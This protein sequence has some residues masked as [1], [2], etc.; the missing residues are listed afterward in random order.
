MAKEKYRWSFFRAG[1]VDQVLL[2]NGQDLHH[3]GELDRKLWLALSCPTRG[4]EFDYR[5]LDLVDTDRDGHIRPA[6][7]LAAV[8]WAGDAFRNLDDLFRG[9][10]KV[11]LSAIKEDTEIGQALLSESRHVLQT[12][13]RDKADAISLDDIADTSKILAA[14]RFNGDGVLPAESAGDEGAA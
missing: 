13:G 8:R 7:I 12:L 14:T 9:G 1:A 5:T 10:A 6:E 3:L 11:A 2:A 4:L